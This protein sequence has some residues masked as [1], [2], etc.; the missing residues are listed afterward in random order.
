VPDA[1]AERARSAIVEQFNALD[2]LAD[3]EKAG[4]REALDDWMRKVRS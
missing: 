4:Y 1:L 3:P 2:P